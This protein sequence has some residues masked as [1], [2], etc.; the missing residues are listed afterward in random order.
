MIKA[1]SGRRISR[2]SALFGAGCAALAMTFPARALAVGGAQSPIDFS[3]H[4]VTFVSSLPRIDYSYPQTSV[5]L[6]NTGSPDQYSTVRADVPAGAAFVTLS[7]VRYDLAQFHWHTP[8]EHKIQSQGA[9]LEMHLVH[10]GTN[11]VVLV[12]AILIEIGSSNIALE[13]IFREL[14]A[15][16]G[17]TRDVLGVNLIALIPPVLESF[18]YSGSHTSVPFN[19]GIEFVVLTDSITLTSQQ[20][21][22]FQALYPT[23]NSRP[24]QPL[25]GRAILSDG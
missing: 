18:R 8:S 20:I 17:A 4:Q 25:N 16:P 6:V 12:I 14:P 13:P 7:G 24:V 1:G 3:E 11:S 5:K 2:R 10:V 21:G 15:L 19:E 9:P 23:G 22:A